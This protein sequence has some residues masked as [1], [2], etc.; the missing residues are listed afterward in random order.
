MPTVLDWSPTVDPSELVRITREAI[1]A[2]SAVVLPGDCG[3][4][5][6]V[7]PAGPNAATQLA[8]L[9][10]SRDA[11]PAVLAWGPDD[12]SG[13]GL[14]LPVGGQ[15]LLSRGWPAPLVVVVPGKPDW[16]A[17]WS[18]AVRYR[19]WADEKVRFRCP[20]HPL[21]D[22]ITP[23]LEMPSLVVDTFLAT[24]EEALDVLDDST[25]VAVSAGKLSID[26]RPTIV[27][28]GESGWNIA[29]QGLL[30]A[31]EVEK[32]SSRIILF[33][34]TGNTCR[35]PLAEVL[36]KRLL[37][38][39]LECEVDDLPRRG[40][41]VVSAGVSASGGGPAALES[42]E[43]AAEFGC[44]LSRHESRPVNP[45]L[46]AAADEV[47]AMTRSHAHTLATRYRGIGPAPILL[48][49]DE[50]LDDPIGAGLGVYRDCARTILQHLDRFLPAWVGS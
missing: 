29:E 38:D 50:D 46:L 45:Q 40:F 17:S 47:I 42:I 19:I 44:D 24:A 18:N 21:F 27:T 16:P 22:S 37:A 33:V 28:V 6:L 23:A 15:R 39:R 10:A 30:P 4:V 48:C 7:N 5:A 9:T 3:Y 31:E 12:P 2:G 36:A 25:A 13:L 34:C 32:L 1:A 14:A 26:E 49:G 43:A 20:E 41:W 11:A 8:A 35:S